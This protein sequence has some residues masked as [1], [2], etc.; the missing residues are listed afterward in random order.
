MLDD[1]QERC[2]RE[3]SDLHA[4]FEEWF[5]GRIAATEENWARLSG[6]LA[7]GFELICPRGTV[8]GRGDLLERLRLEHAA[9]TEGALRIWT[10]NVRGRSIGD[11]LSVV[12]YE[13]WQEADGRRNGRRSSAVFR[14]RAGTP[15]G[16]EWVHL[17]EVAIS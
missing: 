1:V 8:S 9:R 15:N 6:V 12:V 13:E 4:F 7:E 5:T 17:H 11:G 14:E 16:V 2:R 3:I 10:E